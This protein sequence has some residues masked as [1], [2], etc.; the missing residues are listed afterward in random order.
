[1]TDKYEYKIGGSLGENAPS[2]VVRQADTELYRWL[3]AGEFCYIF[4]SRQM[5]KTSLLVRTVKRLKA[6]GY[7]CVTIDISGQGSQEVNIE[8]WYTGIGYTL[9][10]EL[11]IIDITEFFA[12]WDARVKIS[13][14]QRRF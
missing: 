5:G 14:I 11:N 8:Q 1:M 3:K 2:Y 7:A 13:P 10:T 9:A 12:W 4:N 6:E